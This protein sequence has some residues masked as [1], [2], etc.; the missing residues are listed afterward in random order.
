[1][2]EKPKLQKY[3]ISFEKYDLIVFGSPVWA[4]TFAPPLRS[5]ILNE[6]EG[7]KGKRFAAFVCQSGAGGEKAIGKLKKL[8]GVESLEAE[9]VLIDP[10]E[11]PSGENRKKI[12]DFCKNLK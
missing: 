7:L 11:K 9:M 12:E 10:K 4:G 2:A 3:G 8:L 1:M 5:F 6:N